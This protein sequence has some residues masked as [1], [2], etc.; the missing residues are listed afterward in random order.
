M[1]TLLVWAFM[2]SL[3]GLLPD[4]GSEYW[5]YCF[6]LPVDPAE[7][8]Q[9]IDVFRS[10]DLH[11]MGRVTYEAMA[12]AMQ[13]GDHPFSGFLNA[14]RKIVF[15]R[16]MTT[17]AWANTTIAAGDTAEEIDELR[18][19]GDGHVVVW[20]GVGLWR[21]L[22]RLDLI[23]EFRLDVHPYVAGEGTRP[24]DGFPRSYRLELV[25]S[26]PFSNGIVSLHYRRQRE[27]APAS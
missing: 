18:R 1:R 21:S 13:P 14:G 11:V 7:Q 6:G 8:E 25:S 24:F 12:G 19:G 5:R 10:A 3:D 9:K 20:G 23:D 4:E 15:S 26:T 17:A 22:L 16:T 27:A 2:Y